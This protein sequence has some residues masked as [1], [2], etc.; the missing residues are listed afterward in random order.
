MSNMLRDLTPKKFKAGFPADEIHMSHH[1]RNIHLHVNVGGS[2]HPDGEEVAHQA[3]GHH[4][5]H[6][7]A[8]VQIYQKTFSMYQ[9]TSHVAEN[10]T[11]SR[12]P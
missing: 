6:Q 3:D 9:K 4:G 7:E 1:I 11:C 12:K 5:R 8:L 10:F 2:E